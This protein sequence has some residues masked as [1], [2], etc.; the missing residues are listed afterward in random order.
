[1]NLSLINYPTWTANQNN[2]ETICK[3]FKKSEE[4]QILTNNK[5]IIDNYYAKKNYQ[6]R[7]K[8]KMTNN[9]A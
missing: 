3:Y 7:M 2:L 6:L 8:K 5:I 4:I 1:M 9:L